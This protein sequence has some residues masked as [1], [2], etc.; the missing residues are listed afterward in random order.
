M[1]ARVIA[2][3]PNVCRRLVEAQPAHTG[4][5]LRLPIP[6]P[7]LVVVEPLTV[8]FGEHQVVVGGPPVALAQPCQ[9]LGDLGHHRH[10]ADLPGAIYAELGT[11]RG[12]IPSWHTVVAG[13]E[14]A[15]YQALSQWP[16]QD[17]NLR[18]T[19]YES[20]ALTN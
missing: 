18:A 11:Y 16:G 5:A 13:S 14:I 17:S 12:H 6:Q 7:Q 9:R 20:A 4:R 8:R 3:E 10:R 15:A 1:S 19:D 2:S